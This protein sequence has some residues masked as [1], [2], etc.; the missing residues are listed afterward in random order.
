MSKLR[1]YYTTL[2]IARALQ[3]DLDAY[4]SADP[5]FWVSTYRNDTYIF[6]LINGDDADHIIVSA[7]PGITNSGVADIRTDTQL[8]I[9]NFSISAA[10]SA[11]PDM[12]ASDFDSAIDVGDAIT[13]IM[14]HLEPGAPALSY[15]NSPMPSGTFT[16]EFTGTNGQELEA[17]T[18][19]SIAA[20]G[21]LYA[22]IFN[23][24][25]RFVSGRGGGGKSAWQCTDQG[26]A[27][28]YVQAVTLSN[29]ANQFLTVRQVDKDNWVGFHRVTLSATGA[30]LC[31]MVAGSLTDSIITG[32]GS[33][34]DGFKIECDGSTVRL[35]Q[36]T[37]SG[38]SQVG[39]D[40]A[41]TDHQTE[42]SA[43]F[44]SAATSFSIAI[45]DDFENGT[46][47]ATI[48]PIELT[49]TATATGSLTLKKSYHRSLE[50]S[51]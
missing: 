19:W 4:V 39:T 16:D 44:V 14:R 2:V 31:K 43:G 45:Y 26:S 17:R 6:L 11:Y 49:G 18:G 29:D 13:V 35:F 46:V 30:R 47:G 48:L 3:D 23:N 22:R 41:I 36:D 37:G 27:D 40:Q 9:S 20:T 50:G 21:D 5:D 7:T 12:L 8:P 33:N 38:F 15:D 10:V 42:T 32:P 24:A 1:A 51:I 34:G 25:L 28:Q